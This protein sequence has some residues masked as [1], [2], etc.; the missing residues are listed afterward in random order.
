MASAQPDGASRLTSLLGLR[1]KVTLYDG[2]SFIG[3][4]TCI[5]HL[6]NLLLAG[7]IEWAQ[8]AVF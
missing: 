4:L 6:G 2:R 1:C 7:T 8:G 5:D 3:T